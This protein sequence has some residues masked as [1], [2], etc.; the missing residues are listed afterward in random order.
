MEEKLDKIFG[1]I[2]GATVV[3]IVLIYSLGMTIH[4]HLNDIQDKLNNIE[5]I[6]DDVHRQQSDLIIPK[7]FGIDRNEA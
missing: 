4:M 7:L 2:I 6:T 1:C 3:I 5:S